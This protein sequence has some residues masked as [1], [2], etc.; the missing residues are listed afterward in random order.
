MCAIPNLNDFSMRAEERSRKTA[1]LLF[2]G[3]LFLGGEFAAGLSPGD[4]GF[5]EPF[6]EFRPLFSAAG[7]R[8]G[9]LESPLSSQGQ[10]REGKGSILIAPPEALAALS[11]LGFDVLSLGNNHCMDSGV[12]GMQSTMTALASRNIAYVGAGRNLEEARQH[13]IVEC[14]DLRFAFLAY[15]TDA[16][17]V[18]AVLA[19]E[20]SP[21]CVPFHWEIIAE[22]L[23]GA[24][25]ASDV[26]CVSMHWGY[27]YARYPSPDQVGLARR[28]IDHGATIVV[29]HHPHVVQGYEQYGEGIIFYSLGNFFF[30]NYEYQ[31]GLRHSWPEP[32]LTSLIATCSV[33]AGGALERC[34]VIPIRQTRGNRLQLL[35]G[36]ERDAFQRDLQRWSR[37]IHSD[38]YDSFWL[39][40]RSDVK[41]YLESREA[42]KTLQA[43]R[44]QLRQDGLLSLWRRVSPRRLINFLRALMRILRGK[45]RPPDREI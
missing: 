5:H 33:G 20:T 9:N 4:A 45:M 27:E 10:V 17:H 13:R 3:D 7:L 12:E 16:A 22:D 40:H 1:L 14:D 19:S 31:G 34:E 18:S 30:P 43:V 21:G 15:T 39:G 23:E 24:A 29:G 25:R 44:R 6:V 38:D 2:V 36:A 11:F 26:V 32:S 37:T 35:E 28:M 42:G 41:R 8:F